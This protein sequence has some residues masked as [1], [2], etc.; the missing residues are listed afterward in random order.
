M[1]IN[2]RE[3]LLN[4]VIGFG[5][6]KPIDCTA[7]TNLAKALGYGHITYAGHKERLYDKGVPITVVYDTNLD[8]YHVTKKGLRYLEKKN[9]TDA[10]LQ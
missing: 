5:I 1:I 6:E 10:N 9:E 8:Y 2:Y 7:G 3:W 4:I